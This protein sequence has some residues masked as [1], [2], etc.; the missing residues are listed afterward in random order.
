LSR[1]ATNFLFRLD[2]HDPRAYAAAIGVL[3]CA[4]LIASAIPA[5]RAASVDP[6]EALR[7]E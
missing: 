5:R 3:A 1:T 2:A 7:T 6:M 4:A